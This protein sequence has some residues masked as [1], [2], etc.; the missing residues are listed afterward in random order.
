M[1]APGDS[2]IAYDKEALSLE[3]KLGCKV[4]L[5]KYSIIFVTVASSEATATGTKA[6]S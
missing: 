2:R 1:R 3:I 5:S 6:P 4:F